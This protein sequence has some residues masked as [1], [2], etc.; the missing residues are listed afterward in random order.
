MF[1]ECLDLRTPNVVI[2]PNFCGIFSYVQILHIFETARGGGIILVCK[3]RYS[4]RF[5]CI[6]NFPIP[7]HFC[8]HFHTF[9]QRTN[10]HVS[11]RIDSLVMNSLFKKKMFCFAFVSK[12]VFSRVENSGGGCHNAAQSACCSVSFRLPLLLRGMCCQCC[13]ALLKVIFLF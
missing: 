7:L 12:D 8:L 4:F 11:F 13:F 10:L 3:S 6:F 9:A 2:H 5:P 1:Q